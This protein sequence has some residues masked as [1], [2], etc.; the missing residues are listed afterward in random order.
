M[1]DGSPARETPAQPIGRIRVAD[2]SAPPPPEEAA[3]AEAGG[4]S[5][6]GIGIG[7]LLVLV[8][9]GAMV[10]ILWAVFQARGG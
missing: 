3:T 1:A 10:I 8:M 9:V 4:W 7:V 5:L 2:D 6:A